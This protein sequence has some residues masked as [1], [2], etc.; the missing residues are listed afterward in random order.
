MDPLV[1]RRAEGKSPGPPGEAPRAP[2]LQSAHGQ[3]NILGLPNFTA[4][5]PPFTGVHS[6][7]NPTCCWFSRTLKNL[8][9]RLP[10][11]DAT[12][13]WS[14]DL[15]HNECQSNTAALCA[16]GTPCV[17][18]KGRF[19]G[20]GPLRKTCVKDLNTRLQSNITQ[21][22]KHLPAQARTSDRCPAVQWPMPLIR[23]QARPNHIVR[24][25]AQRRK[26]EFA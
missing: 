16:I 9:A 11:S 17:G 23:G 15:H 1:A 14:P 4:A 18:K 6:R 19:F 20:R 12:N 13:F 5:S 8:V 25:H 22:A 26:I 2:C 10:F 7:T 3:T 24:R 21:P